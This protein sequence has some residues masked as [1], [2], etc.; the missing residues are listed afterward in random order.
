MGFKI[1]DTVT[2]LWDDTPE[3]QGIIG[4]KVRV[5]RQPDGGSPFWMDVELDGVG[6]SV[7]GSD[8]RK[9]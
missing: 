9:G 7:R 5:V 2:L 4:K 3:N 6:Y 1:G 8:C